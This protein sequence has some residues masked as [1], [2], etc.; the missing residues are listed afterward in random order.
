MDS[1][2]G[3]LLGV[4]DDWED[5]AQEAEEQEEQESEGFGCLRCGTEME[6]LKE[7]KI[8]L[9]EQG[10]F[11]DNWSHIAAGALSVHI[12]RCPVCG[13]LEFFDPYIFENGPEEEAM[14]DEEIEQVQCPNCGTV[15]DMDYP[16][17]PNCKYEYQE[18]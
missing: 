10:F 8:Q 13:K 15:H 3:A 16:R 14:E 18:E 7:T 2:F 17:C 5:A 9:G 1:I 11:G 6:Y 4:S 12:F